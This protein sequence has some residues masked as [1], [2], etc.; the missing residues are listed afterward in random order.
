MFCPGCGIRV[1]DDLKFCRQCGANLRGVQEAMVSRTAGDKFDWSKTWVAEMFMSREESERRKGVTP[2]IKRLNEIKARVITSLAGLGGMIFLRFLL[3]AVANSE[4]GKDAEIL[5]SV[6]MAGL[7][8]FLVGLGLIFNGLIISRRIVRLQTQSL[9]QAEQ[10]AATA[11]VGAKTTDQL[12]I[13]AASSTATPAGFSVTET[14][15][16]HLPEPV[17]ANPRPETN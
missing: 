12:A 16:A 3:T 1:T 13:P 2:E 15:T 14:T 11:S 9:R 4:G 10:A 6:W 17:V 7:V 8:P 5:R